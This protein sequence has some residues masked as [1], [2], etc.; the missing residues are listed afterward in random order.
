SASLPEGYLLLEDRLAGCLIDH[1]FRTVDH[2][3]LPG[4]DAGSSL[5]LL[6]PKE[7]PQFAPDRSAQQPLPT[8]KQ[9]EQQLA[10]TPAVSRNLR[11]DL[12]DGHE[13]FILDDPDKHTP[14]ER[15][16]ASELNRTRELLHNTYKHLNSSRTELQSATD[17]LAQVGAELK[18]TKAE[19]RSVQYELRVLKES[20]RSRVKDLRLANQCLEK[21]IYLTD[22]AA[23]FLDGDY[24]LLSYTPAVE[25]LFCLSPL[26]IGIPIDQIQHGLDSSRLLDDA[27]RVFKTGASIQSE[28]QNTDGRWFLVRISRFQTN[29]NSATGVVISFIDVTHLKEASIL[30]EEATVRHGQIMAEKAAE[31]QQKEEELKREEKK[32]KELQRRVSEISNER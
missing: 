25:S 17:S 8:K 30:L 19:L 31:L 29:K 13:P 9:E 11:S 15:Y 18:V 20:L 32:R 6:A 7:I 22:L 10:G 12:L 5:L 21:T 26:D 28:V 14:L 4:V 1:F 2:Q 23:I 16:L 27:A 24:R 3:R